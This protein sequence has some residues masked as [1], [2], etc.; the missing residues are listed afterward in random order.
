MPTLPRQWRLDA[1]I[2]CRRLSNALEETMRAYRHI[3]K[4]T[5]RRTNRS[6]LLYVSPYRSVL[7]IIWYQL[8]GRDAM[9]HRLKWFI[10]LWAQGLNKRDEHLTNTPH[11]VWYTPPL[12]K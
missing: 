10:D 7:S 9:R 5:D 4:W 6:I 12:P 8:Y 1:A 2:T 3:A 11:A